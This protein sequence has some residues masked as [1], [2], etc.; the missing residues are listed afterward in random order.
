MEQLTEQKMHGI[1]IGQTNTKIGIKT[2]IQR[3]ELKKNSEKTNIQNHKMIQ[4]KSK[5]L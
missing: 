5:G 1:L 3:T 4:I 2:N